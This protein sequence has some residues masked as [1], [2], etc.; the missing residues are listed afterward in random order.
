MRRSPAIVWSGKRPD[1]GQLDAVAVAVVAAEQLVAAADGE[2]GGAA[3]DRLVHGVGL[4]GE[5][6]RDERLLAVLAAADVEQVVRARPQRVAHRDRLDVELVPAPRRAPREHG[7]VAAVGVDVQVVRVEVPD[8]D[9]HAALLPVRP[10]VRRRSPISLRSASI[11]V[12]VGRTTS[13]S[14]GPDSA[15]PRSSAAREVGHDL[16]PLRREA[17]VLAA[18]RELGGA[19]S[20]RDDALE[21]VEQRLEVDVPDPRDVL[22]VGDRVVERDHGD[23]AELALRR[24]CGSPRSRRPGS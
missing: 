11:A 1:P 3:R 22:A 7:D 4:R 8:A 9:L 10:H 2:H 24:A 13:S 12:Y 5:V 23:A 18:Q 16:D 14:A 21:P 15:S 17:R 20:R 19:V 6:D